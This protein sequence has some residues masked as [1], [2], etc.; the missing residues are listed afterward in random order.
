MY[1]CVF[2]NKKV[3]RSRTQRMQAENAQDGPNT[4]CIPQPKGIRRAPSYARDV[5]AEERGEMYRQQHGEIHHI[6][7]RGGGGGGGC[8]SLTA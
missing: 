1:Y 5:A 8:I 3:P 6:F 2:C 7:S 4:S